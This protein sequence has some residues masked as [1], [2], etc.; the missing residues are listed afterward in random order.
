MNNEFSEDIH[1]A[2]ESSRSQ[3]LAASIWLDNGSVRSTPQLSGDVGMFNGFGF[4]SAQKNETS[5]PVKPS[6]YKEGGE[7]LDNLL[8]GSK[9]EKKLP[10]G[11]TIK[12]TDESIYEIRLPKPSSDIFIINSAKGTVKDA[13]NVECSLTSDS[14]GNIVIKNQKEKS[15]CTIKK[16][17]S[18]IHNYP[19]G[20]SNAERE[21]PAHGKFERTSYIFDTDK[22][23]HRD[24]FY[25]IRN[26]K[27]PFKAEN[28]SEISF[29]HKSDGGKVTVKTKDGKTLVMEN[30]VLTI[31]DKDGKSEKFGPRDGKRVEGYI[32]TRSDLYVEFPNGIV[33]NFGHNGHV[34]IMIKNADGSTTYAAYSE[35]SPQVITRKSD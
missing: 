35:G 18:V 14:S 1:S 25:S 17:G 30:Q 20:S 13:E 22:L 6:S 15:S 10:N 32:Q 21:Y 12:R 23:K 8:A 33:G 28:G 24:D 19:N 9:D 11:L 4:A 29:E 34:G 26:L 27:E 3:I 5:E 7:V 31:T 2:N 16:D